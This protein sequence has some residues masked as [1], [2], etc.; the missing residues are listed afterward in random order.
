MRKQVY[1]S[2][3]VLSVLAAAVLGLGPAYN[4]GH[5]LLLMPKNCQVLY[6]AEQPAT[7]TFSQQ[8]NTPVSDQSSQHLRLTL[9]WPTNPGAFNIQIQDADTDTTGNYVTIATAGTITSAPQAAGGGNFVA[10]V[11]LNPWEANFG[12][13]FVQTQT[14]NA[15]NLTATV[16]R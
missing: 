5:S 6:N 9:V 13:L 14:A 4:T 11:E 10:R 15:V 2:L 1:R 3:A 16:C 12:R 7:G 8:F